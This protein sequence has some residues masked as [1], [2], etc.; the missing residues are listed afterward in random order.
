MKKKYPVVVRSILLAFTYLIVYGQALAQEVENTDIIS[1]IRNPIEHFREQ[2][3][4]GFAGSSPTGEVSTRLSND[5]MPVLAT[6]FWREDQF[7][8]DGYKNFIDT[9]SIHSPYNILAA[10]IRLP[11]REITNDA[12]HDQVKLV[13]EY[14]ITR[15]IALVADLDVR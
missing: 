2:K 13:T 14:A 8:P 6:W 15:G 5:I 4:P 12:V 3:Y 11:G 1:N 10:S 7:K 9:V